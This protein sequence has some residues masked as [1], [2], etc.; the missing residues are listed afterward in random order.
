[1][2]EILTTVER[3]EGTSPVPS[4]MRTGLG[5]LSINITPTERWGR[6]IVGLIGFVFGVQLIVSASSLL[7]G[8]LEGLLIAAGLDLIVAGALGH[9]PLYAWFGHVP[10]SLRRM[11]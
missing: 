1:M 10:T 11:S 9:C 3:T 8:V 6:V 5:G 4:G 2:K 7:V